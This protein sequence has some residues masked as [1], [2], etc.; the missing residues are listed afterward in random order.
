MKKPIT[1]RLKAYAVIVHHR[2]VEQ[3]ASTDDGLAIYDRIKDAEKRKRKLIPEVKGKTVVCTIT[4][5]SSES[6]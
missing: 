1:K 2:G 4:Y 3:I 5:Q 6:E